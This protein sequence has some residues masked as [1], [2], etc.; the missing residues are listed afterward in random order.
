[1]YGST[2]S[3]ALLVFISLLLVCPGLLLSAVSVP[4]YTLLSRGVHGTLSF[5]QHASVD[6]AV[7]MKNSKEILYCPGCM[8]PIVLLIWSV[9]ALY[10]M[11]ALHSCINTGYHG[12]TST[13]GYQACVR[14]LDPVCRPCFVA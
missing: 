9:S 6:D 12:R 10:R 11:Q 5:T 2:E 3:I 1:M 14:E 4:Q 13:S 7:V 8:N